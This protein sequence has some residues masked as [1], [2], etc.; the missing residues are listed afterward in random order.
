MVGFF[1]FQELNLATADLGRFI[2]NGENIFNGSWQNVLHSNFYSYTYTQYPFLNHHWG[3]GAIF[4][5]FQQIGGFL[6]VHLFAI[7]LMLATFLIL[8]KIT[9]KQSG[10]AVATLLSLLLIPVMAYRKEIRPE[11]F[12]CLFSAVFAYIL[13]SYRNKEISAR[14]LLTLPLLEVFWVNLHI[15]FFLGPA[16][17]GAFL[18]EKIIFYFTNQQERLKQIIFVFG[19]TLVA[20]CVNPFGWKGAIHPFK[21]YGNYGYRIL[22]EQSVWFLENLNIH[23]PSFTLFKIIA[24]SL[25]VSFVWIL[26]KKRSEFSLVNFFLM[27]GIGFMACWSIRNISLFAFMSLPIL[28]YNIKIIAPKI[29][30][31]DFNKKI[32]F[33]GIAVIIVIIMCAG[34]GKY[35]PVN[36]GSFGLGVPEQENRAMDFFKNHNLRGPIFNNYD[37]GGYLIYHLFPQEKV[38]VDNRPETYPADFFQ[39]VYVPMQEDEQIWKE[40]NKEYDFNAIIFYLRDATPWGQKF[41]IARVQDE[42]WTPVFADNSIIIFLKNN[43]MNK[44]VIEQYEMPPEMFRIT[45]TI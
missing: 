44:E 13:W 39:S 40:K 36:S 25:I 23:N 43:E 2:K 18:L 5:F 16:I 12:S 37:I 4:Y 27:A 32:Y 35:L 8:F 42:N 30:F 24:F 26:I 21:I 33:A 28:A 31:S 11:I 10:W 38:F 9:K 6:A 29:N 41:L 14:W 3:T 17:I 34:Y 20:S 45:Q 1:L 7:V 15:Y 19:L 22:E